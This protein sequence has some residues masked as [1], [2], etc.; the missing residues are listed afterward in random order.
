MG[1][2]KSTP[3]NQ[4]PTLAEMEFHDAAA[5]HEPRIVIWK[6]TGCLDGKQRSHL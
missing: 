2:T 3:E 5:K 1:H 4:R 6:I